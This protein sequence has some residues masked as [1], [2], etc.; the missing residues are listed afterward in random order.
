M[1]AISALPH[2]KLE[3][4][5]P[6][7]AVAELVRAQSASRHDRESDSPLDKL[8]GKPRPHAGRCG[9]TRIPRQQHRPDVNSPKVVAVATLRL[10]PVIRALDGATKPRR[11]K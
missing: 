2:Y 6:G 7:R 11:P 3:F 4:G 9:G 8:K 5:R 10:R 1:R